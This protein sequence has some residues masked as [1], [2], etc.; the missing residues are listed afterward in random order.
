MKTIKKGSKIVTVVL[1]RPGL[2]QVEIAKITGMSRLEV[3]RFCKAY[4][5]IG[6]ISEV[7]GKYYEG[8]FFKLLLKRMI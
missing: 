3:H 4:V 6:W 5:E 8:D 7:F 2:K 1:E